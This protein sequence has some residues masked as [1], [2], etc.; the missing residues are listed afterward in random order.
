MRHSKKE[1]EKEKDKDKS[2]S[3]DNKRAEKINQDDNYLSYNV[4]K[5]ILT[6]CKI[7]KR[8]IEEKNSE[9]FYE[10]L[11]GKGNL[12]FINKM[13]F[14][15]FM[16]NGLL[17]SG[18]NKEKCQI[19][20][21]DGTK[22][23]GEIHQ[24]K[25]TGNGK[26]IFPSGSIYEGS[27]LNGLRHG[28]GKYVSPEGITYEG[29]W[30]NGLKDGKGTMKRDTM[31]YEGDWK[32]GRI[33]GFGKIHWA[34]GNLYDGHFKMNHIDG[35]GFMV[36]YDLLEKYIGKWK[37]D[38]QNGFGMNIWYEPKGEMKEMRNRYVGEWEDGIKQ[39][40]GIFFY[41]NGAMYEG[42]WKN[43]MK[44]GFGVMISED[45]KKYIGR[46]EEDRILD[47]DN[48]LNSEEVKKKLKE[49][50][51]NKINNL[52]FYEE[53]KEK[54]NGVNNIYQ[55]IQQKKNTNQE[56]NQSTVSSKKRDQQKKLI[57]MAPNKNISKST[58]LINS[59][60]VSHIQTIKEKNTIPEEEEDNNVKNLNLKGINNVPSSRRD[61]NNKETKKEN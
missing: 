20:F 47:K 61:D 23:E 39:G 3:Y 29:E 16:K 15:G 13:R 5:E 60:E 12:T 56:L 21:S 59:K 17:E 27:L 54:V 42:E 30:K 8:I 28:M 43:N 55:I 10:T 33:N 26:Y 32:E 34:N 9:L 46:F 4:L 58:L 11:T 38:K 31:T 6:E 50:K 35:N 1:K 37:D 49:Y 53:N 7:P 14:H 18:P 45:G 22:Y 40:Y 24:N 44:H 25:I 41:S 48:Q 2:I 51:L 19:I 57:G 52:K 36:W